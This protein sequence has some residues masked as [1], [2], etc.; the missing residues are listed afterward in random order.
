MAKKG[1]DVMIAVKP[2]RGALGGGDIGS[3]RGIDDPGAEADNPDTDP[4]EEPDADDQQLSPDEV[5]YSEHD[6]CESCAHNS[7]GTCSK[8]HF[9]VDDTGHCAAGYEPQQQ[10]GTDQDMGAQG[11]PQQGA[12]GR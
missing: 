6:L 7:S 1:M 12:Y 4:A 3:P 10:G 11:P 8:Y 9:P 5:C 2:H